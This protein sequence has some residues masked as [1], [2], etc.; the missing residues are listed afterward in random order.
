MFSQDQEVSSQLIRFRFP[1][2][3]NS[4]HMYTSTIVQIQITDKGHSTYVICA[5]RFKTIHKNQRFQ[6]GGY[7]YD[8][9]TEGA[10]FWS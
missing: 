9:L 3:P 2:I 4:Q 1:P 6:R 5:L 7:I 8:S 10:N